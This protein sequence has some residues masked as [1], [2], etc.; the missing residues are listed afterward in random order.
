PI[1]CAEMLTR[2]FPNRLSEEAAKRAQSSGAKKAMAYVYSI[3]FVRHEGLWHGYVSG[4]LYSGSQVVK[5]E[6][7]FEDRAVKYLGRFSSR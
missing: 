2:D 4:I 3:V 6:S 7:T 1:S 5:I